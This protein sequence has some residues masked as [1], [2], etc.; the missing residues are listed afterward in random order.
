[1][2][3]GTPLI[4]SDSSVSSS[5]ATWYQALIYLDFTERRKLY[6]TL[7]SQGLQFRPGTIHT[8]HILEST[9][10]WS[11]QTNITFNFTDDEVY[12]TTASETGATIIVGTPNRI[13][14][15]P[16]SIRV[17]RCEPFTLRYELGT[18]KLD[19]TQADKKIQMTRENR[20]TFMI[21]LKGL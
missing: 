11:S 9:R 3:H 10:D 8:D 20:T 19:V 16:S 14:V 17:L 7:L 1:M 5:N 18:I 13:Q 21:G 4:Y 15:P 12:R 2:S 6:Q